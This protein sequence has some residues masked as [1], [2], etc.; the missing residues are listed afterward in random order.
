M[1]NP[2]IADRDFRLA[3]EL[4]DAGAAGDLRELLERRPELLSMRLEGLEDFAG[5]YFA[6][7]Y[8]LWFV[9]ENPI[10]NRT[11]PGNIV[12]VIDALVETARA[13]R[14]AGLAGQLDYTLALVASGLV[15]R[16]QGLQAAMITA[17]VGHGARPDAAM[18]PALAHSELE[19][20]RALLQ[21]GATADLEV[22]ASVGATE[23]LERLFGEASDEKRRRALALA[24][25]HGEPE[26]VAFL[27]RAGVDPNRHNPEG[28]HSH[29]TPLH[30]AVSMGRIE[31]VRT[32]LELGA[33]PTI[34]DTLFDGD[35]RGWARH[36]E[37][38][39]ILRLLGDD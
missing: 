39:D 2:P 27:V 23:G 32:L 9:A 33:D 20:V 19:A 3:V 25:L 24:A 14:I 18:G 6:S 8:L 15:P 29:A 16:E 4:I 11:L 22:A 5:A 30:N 37:R 10:R 12:E 17:L 1:P 35:A 21:L 31:T 28:C 13:R 26:A 36:F 38:E 34:R 7:P